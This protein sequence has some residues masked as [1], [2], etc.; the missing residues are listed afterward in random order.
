MSYSKRAWEKAIRK[1]ATKTEDV[2]FSKHALSQ[3]KARKI[4]M[5][6]AL[7][8]LRKGVI[9]R[10][11]EPDIKTGHTKCTM[12]RYTAGMSIAVV[13][14]CESESAVHCVVVTSFVIGG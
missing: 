5:T 9:N 6:M 4:T 11:P 8:V 14:A 7:D 13:A 12:E 3:M 1:V 10:E 2:M